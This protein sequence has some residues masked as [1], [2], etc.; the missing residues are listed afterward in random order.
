MERDQRIRHRSQHDERGGHEQRG[1][2][3]AIGPNHDREHD[4][5]QRDDDGLTEVPPEH[6]RAHSVRF[7]FPL[8]AFEY[9][10]LDL[11]R[12]HEADVSR[13]YEL[14]DHHD[15]VPET[16]GRRN[17]QHAEHEVLDKPHHLSGK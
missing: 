14:A 9:G 8:R 13:R 15:E 17:Q 10:K 4:D 6:G 2:T 12:A 11:G 7:V 1:R 3:A 16:E 5:P